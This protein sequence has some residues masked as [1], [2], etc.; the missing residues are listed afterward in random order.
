MARPS[1]KDLVRV[2]VSAQP[3]GL[4]NMVVPYVYG[5]RLL[6]LTVVAKDDKGKDVSKKWKL[7]GTEEECSP[8]GSLENGT[9]QQ[10]S[11]LVSTAPRG[12]MVGKIGGSTADLPD[13]SPA[14]AAG[15]Y[16]GR[17]VF[18]SG[19]YTVVGLASTDC[20]PLFLTMND[21]PKGFCNHSGDLWVLIEEAPL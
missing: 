7:S 8:D 1:W 21:S 5:P 6:Q 13:T 20:G 17:K 3:E 12:A 2:R 11:L 9:P 16:A 19:T 4:W 15:P 10:Q 18:V 14:G